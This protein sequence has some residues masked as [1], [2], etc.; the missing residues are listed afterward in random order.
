M[1]RDLQNIFTNKEY[2]LLI[3]GG[4][5]NGAAIANI[6]SQQGLSVALVEKEDFASGTSSRSTKLV[7]G[8][9]R[10]LENFEFDLV[11]ESLR[12]RYIQW[13]SVP[14]LVQPL[15]F[16]IPVYKGD[17]RPLWMMKLGVF[18]Y[19]LLSGKYVVEKHAG[20]TAEQV[21]A[22]I[23]GI[24]R[25]GLVGGVAY[26][27]CRMDDARLCL[28]NILSA[29][30]K[31]AHIANYVQAGSFL[32]VATQLTAGAN[33][34]DLLTGQEMTIKAHHVVCAAGPW[35]NEILR[36]DSPSSAD[37]IRLTKGVHIVYKEKISDTAL[38][39]QAGKD[40][41]VFFAIP[42]GEHTL[43]GTTDTDYTASPDHVESEKE[44]IEYLLVETAKFLPSAKLR[45]ENIVTS[46][47][48]LRPLVFAQGD[49][50][51]I[52]RNHVI[53]KN[54]S[55]VWYVM[56]GKYTTYRAIAQQCVEKVLGKKLDLGTDYSLYGSQGQRKEHRG[57]PDQVYQYLFSKYG[58]KAEDVLKLVEKDKQ[59]AEPL[60][61]CSPA[62]KAQVVY[63]LQNE[64]AVTADDI[65]WRRL[66]IGYVFCASR[67]CRKVIEEYCEA[68][69]R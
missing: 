38:L 69:R 64:M 18:L 23:P 59:L 4:G 56:G 12:E 37:K 16:V 26:S 50:S 11:K 13:K 14:H 20:L 5:I 41:R 51:K 15:R 17:R 24:K 9:L 32:K 67:Q 58:Y 7:H 66:G 60:C 62:I 54:E 68:S 61:T 44:D 48:G 43:I 28:E 21:V 34:K 27:D 3:I 33:V 45:R 63:A 53:E 1:K 8:G 2:D 47:A 42:F 35:T 19:D 52:S 36:L 30:E 29:R 6:A 22:A 55:G 46:F 39:L 49:P 25:E 31:G 57:L 10:Y 65:I 40:N